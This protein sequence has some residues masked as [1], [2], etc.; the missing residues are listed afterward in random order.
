MI[1]EK[2]AILTDSKETSLK[3]IELFGPYM[4]VNYYEFLCNDIILLD[5]NNGVDDWK[6]IIKNELDI[7]VNVIPIEDLKF[8]TNAPTELAA[9]VEEFIKK[10]NI[11]DDI[12]YFLDLIT[13]KGG[14]VWLTSKEQQRLDELNVNKKKNINL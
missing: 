11:S 2:Y 7:E 8:D 4:A 1:Y 3:V 10:A 12:N 13:E 9:G 14:I 5:S 6:T